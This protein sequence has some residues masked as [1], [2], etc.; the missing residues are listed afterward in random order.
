MVDADRRHVAL[1][2]LMGVGKTVIGRAL[3]HRL[4][5]QLI[6]LDRAIEATAGVSVPRIFADE[7]E[8]IFR[9]YERQALAELASAPPAV[10]ALGGGAFV[11]DTNVALVRAV[12]VTCWL[13]AP[14]ATILRRLG[15]NPGR[16]RPLLAVDSPLERL[17]ALLQERTPWYAQADVHVEVGSLSA[18]EA[19]TCIRQQLDWIPPSPTPRSPGEPPPS[20]A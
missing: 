12:A 20:G 4:G 14:P 10:V 13:Q 15:P 8:A 18:D 6:D 11:G 19:A 9:R 17:E 7:G 5:R 3:A 2:G 1:L 16:W